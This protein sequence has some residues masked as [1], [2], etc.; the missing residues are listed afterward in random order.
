M[1]KT[2]IRSLV[3]ED[4]TYHGS[5]KPLHHSYWACALE[6]GRRNYWSPHALDSPCS[7]E[8]AT[9]MRSPCATT[10]EEPLIFTTREKARVAMKKQHGQKEINNLKK[11]KG[12]MEGEKAIQ[13]DLQSLLG[14]QSWGRGNEMPSWE[15]REKRVQLF[16][17]SHFVLEPTSFFCFGFTV[18]FSKLWLQAYMHTKYKTYHLKPFLNVQFNSV[19]HILIVVTMD[20]QNFFIFQNWNLYPLNNSSS[21]PSLLSLWQP[22]VLLFSS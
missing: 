6:P 10:R 13:W 16:V 14:H 8:E 22:P 12:K 5:T 9:T 20:L 4:P 1:K 7:T 3:Q 19:I 21:L 11:K 2:W 18:V 17:H 15:T